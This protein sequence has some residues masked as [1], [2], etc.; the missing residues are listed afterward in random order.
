MT[1]WFRGSLVNVFQPEKPM[2]GSE[3]KDPRYSITM[4]FD[5][6]AVDISEMKKL[7]AEVGRAKWGEKF[8]K[9]S[10]D[11]NFKNPFRS[12]DAKDYD[13]YEGMTFVRAS[14]K[15][16]PGIVDG[17][18]NTITEDD[19]PGAYSGAYYRATVSAF[20]FDN[21]SKGIAF[22]LE[23]VQKLGEGE[24]FGT[25]RVD[26]EDDFGAVEG[27]DGPELDPFA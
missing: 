10:K 26:A 17:N 24:P 25:R 4:L 20:A 22:N 3:S 16:R 1:P 2:A 21:V 23:N 19:V 8:D 13:G 18:R 14:T 15:H 12:G 5:E 11:P 7:A 27:Y 6:S 9:L